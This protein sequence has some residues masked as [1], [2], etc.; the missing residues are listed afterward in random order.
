M[1]GAFLLRLQRKGINIK[2]NN[3]NTKICN[4]CGKEFPLDSDHFFKNCNSKDGYTCVCKECNGYSFTKKL[5]NVDGYKIC[6]KCNRKLPLDINHFI[7]DKLCS[8]GFRNVCRE[9]GQDGHFMNDNYKPKK[10]W[11]EED[12]NL[13]KERYPCYTNNELIQKYY[14][15]ATL[16]SLQDRAY[17]LGITGKDEE[18]INRIGKEVSE[19]TS[20]E[21][22]CN[23]GKSKS[24]EQINKFKNSIKK[25]YEKHDS[26]LKGVKWDLDDHR[27]TDMSNRKKGIWS[28]NNNPRHINP[29]FNEENP[30]WNGGINTLYAELRSEINKWKQ[31]SM[32]AC[33]YKCVITGKDFDEI[34]HLYPFKNILQETFMNLNMDIKHQVKDYT[35]EEF[36]SIKIELIR[37]HNKYGLGVCLTKDIHK[38]FHDT[39]GY[40]NTTAEQFQEFKERYNNGEFAEIL[41]F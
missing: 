21:N 23:Y 35:N 4:K 40:T 8:D 12:N 28:G 36:N 39:Y 9:C 18:V 6:I 2:V 16:K 10:R 34:H 29:L 25:Y 32:I 31:Q 20:G 26:K 41:V 3:T 11:T 27:R 13:F 17:R 22:S 5:K 33:H 30:N 19:K 7:P 24:K 15:D 1:I 37:L 14:P 38:L